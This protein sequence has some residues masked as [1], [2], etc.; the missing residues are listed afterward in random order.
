MEF[1]H[2]VAPVYRVNKNISDR[3]RRSRLKKQEAPMEPIQLL[4]NFL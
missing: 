3:L 2:G 1:I 4:L